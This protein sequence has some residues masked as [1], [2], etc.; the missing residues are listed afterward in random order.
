M[1]AQDMTDT[2]KH[3]HLDVP[4]TKIGDNT[5]PALTTLAAIF[6]KNLNNPPVQATTTEKKA[7][8]NKQL[9]D[10]IKPDITPSVKH[11][12]QT[13]LQTKSN[14]SSPDNTIESK[15]SPQ[16]LRVVTPAERVTEPL[17]VL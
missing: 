13:R 6:T 10:L 7:V 9:A 17:R 2:L 8:E 3:P 11:K 16:P 12:H 15:K 4:F 14:P 1:E 5:I